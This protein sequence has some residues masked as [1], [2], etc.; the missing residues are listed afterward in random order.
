LRRL[1][2]PRL[3]FGD[4]GFQGGNLPLI[5]LDDRPQERL[6]L[7]RQRGQLLGS[8]RRLRHAQGVANFR[9]RAKTS[10]SL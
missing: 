3:Q 10:F 8:D 7:R 9:P 5:M 1:A 2:E 6:K 4:P